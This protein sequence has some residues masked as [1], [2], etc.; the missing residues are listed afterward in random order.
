VTKDGLLG[1][2]FTG[3][4]EM[5]PVRI[6]ASLFTGP[7]GNAEAPRALEAR[8]EAHAK[9]PPHHKIAYWIAAATIHAIKLW[10]PVRGFP[11]WASVTPPPNA[12]IAMRVI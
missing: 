1:L 7:T 6:A 3:A 5:L 4:R 12:V 9:N 11:D 8:Q 2:C 10:L